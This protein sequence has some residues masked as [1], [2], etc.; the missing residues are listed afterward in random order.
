MSYDKAAV[1]AVLEQVRSDGRAALTAQEGTLVC[2]AYEIATPT[3]GLALS[4]DAAAEL[5][6]QIG[7]PVVL[8]IASTD[9]LHKTDAG[10]VLPGID[11]PEE[12]ARAYDTILENARAYDADAEITGVLVQKMHPAAQEAPN[13]RN[14]KAYRTTLR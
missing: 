5:A 4:A 7:F 3:D 10:G 1:Q 8:K 9:I 13:K 12:A 11:S 6:E 14:R 2:Q